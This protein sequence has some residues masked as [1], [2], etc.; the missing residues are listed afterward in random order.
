MKF[1]VIGDFH[2][3]TR[4]LIGSPNGFDEREAAENRLAEIVSGHIKKHHVDYSLIE[5]ADLQE[6]QNKGIL[7]MGYP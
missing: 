2:D 7:L 5:A 6:V 4:R 1:W 3:D